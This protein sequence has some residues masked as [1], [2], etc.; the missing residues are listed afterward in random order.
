[1]TI[2]LVKSQKAN[3][4]AL[5]YAFKD[6]V[7]AHL[8]VPIVHICR[9]FADKHCVDKFLRRVAILVD[10]ADFEVEIGLHLLDSL[11]EDD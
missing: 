5:L 10:Q 6:E 3:F 11:A 8:L 1:M 9:T 4:R 7:V 2:M